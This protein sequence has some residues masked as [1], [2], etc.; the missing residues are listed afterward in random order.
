MSTGSKQMLLIVLAPL[1]LLLCACVKAGSPAHSGDSAAA[2]PAMPEPGPMP[3]FEVPEAHS[4]KLSNGIPVTFVQ[5]GSIP[6]VQLQL[7]IHSGSASD[8]AGM[9]GRAS[10]AAAMLKE[11]TTEHSAIELSEL[12]LDL[13][14]G[15]GMSTSLEHSAASLRCLEDKLDETLALLA[16]ML[17]SSTFNEADFERLREQRRSSLLAEQDRLEVL[18]YRAFRRLV[19]GDSYAGRS[20]RG[21]LDSIENITVQDLINWHAR[22]WIPAN[23]SLVMVSRMSPELAQA[24]LE[25]ALGSW[26][27]GDFAAA[28]QLDPIPAAELAPQ[29]PA[30]Q[31]G[32]RQDTAVY[33]IDRPGA[34]Q[35]YI[36]VG[37]SAPAWDAQLQAS[38]SLGNSPLGGQFTARL[39]M[40]LREDK[41]YTYGARSSVSGLQQG[42]S[43]RARAS[44]KTATTAKALVEFLYEIKGI[45]GER[46][47]QADEFAAGQG[48]YLQGYPSYF[49]GIQGVL[50]QFA[51]A[52]AKQRPE[53]WLAGY[54]K[55]ISAVTMEQAQA[56]LNDMIDPDKLVI[57]VVGDYA[58]VGAEV[59]ALELGAM[60]MLD[61]HGDPIVKTEDGADSEAGD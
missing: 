12:L 61:I 49:E 51:S 60:V 15:V 28:M 17:R 32:A 41:G 36:T 8:P 20:A 59:A 35:S 40:N 42:G 24:A 14:S 13:S 34:A 23:A 6:M 1:A 52:D 50:S 54:R 2:W 58:A 43:F 46:P 25:R 55:R 48:R 10:L 38:R 37:Q 30:Y 56:Q 47:I 45:V 27:P 7:N 44:V 16:S 39:N 29:P 5:V 57:V 19:Y 26:Q 3:G 4:F 22:A 11:G 53:G 33:W 21:T 18:G 31:Q 9:S